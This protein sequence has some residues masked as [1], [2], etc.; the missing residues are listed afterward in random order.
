MSIGQG[1]WGILVQNPIKKL[2]H[3]ALEQGGA[4]IGS[5]YPKSKVLKQVRKDIE[6][7]N[8]VFM[9]YQVNQSLKESIKGRLLLNDDFFKSFSGIEN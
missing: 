6:T 3:L 1:Y 2:W 5:G 8:P 7:G 9:K 4:I